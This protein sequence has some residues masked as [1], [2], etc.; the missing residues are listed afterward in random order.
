MKPVDASKMLSNEKKDSVGLMNCGE[1]R[2]AKQNG[3][4]RIAYWIHKFFSHDNL[5]IEYLCF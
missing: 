3:L 2:I 1:Q 4:L 5:Q